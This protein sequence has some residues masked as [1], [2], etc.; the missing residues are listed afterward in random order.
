MVSTIEPRF[1]IVNFPGLRVGEQHAIDPDPDHR[2]HNASWRP[3]CS[4][5]VLHNLAERS[6]FSTFSG[7]DLFDNR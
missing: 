1:N 4:A 2:M 7:H 6:V 3:N 5:F